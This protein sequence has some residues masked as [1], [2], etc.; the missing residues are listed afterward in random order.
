MKLRNSKLALFFT[1]GISLRN[2]EEIGVLDRE[3]KPYKK[4]AKY[5]DEIY[6]FT[7]GDKE[8]LKYKKILP[9]NIK[10]FPKKLNLPPLLY[11]FLLPFLYRLELRNVDIIKTNQMPGSWAAVV[12]KFLYRKK[13]VVRCGYEWLRNMELKREHKLKRLLA[14]ILEFLAYKTADKIIITSHENRNFIIERFKI[15]PKKIEVVPNYIDTNLFKPIK[16]KKERRLIFI[17][18][19]EREKNLANL[20]KAVSKL[21][22]KLVIFGNGSLKEELEKLAKKLK[23]NVEFKG[24][25][26]NEKLPLE[27]NKSEIF[28]L[29]SLYENCPKT[30]LEAMSCGLPCIGTNVPGIREIIKHKEN[31]Y[32]CGTDDKSI[33]KAIKEVL[34]N[35]QL[36]EKISKN[37]RK[38]ILENFS[39]ERI[40]EN[41]IKV[42]EAL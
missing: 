29:P 36:R 6:L 24:N 16:V 38:T 37:A 27:L 34:E 5:F 41:E 25:I 31:G 3:L 22:I 30:L 10:I 35:K 28:I 21:D 33:R 19:L 40:L 12:A 8:D 11:S 4:F 39:L 15:S 2:W 32:L 14:F 23:S 18:R 26:P 7:Y 17:G 1:K 20:I 13:L 42:F 9:D